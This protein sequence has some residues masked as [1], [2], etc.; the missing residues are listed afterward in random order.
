MFIVSFLLRSFAQFVNATTE[1]DLDKCGQHLANFVATVGIDIVIGI[2]FKKAAG[3]A[4]DAGSRGRENRLFDQDLVESSGRSSQNYT[5]DLSHVTGKGAK[6]RQRAI[7]SILKEDFN[8]LNF[9][10]LPEYSPFIRTGI[11]KKDAGT[12]IGK[13]MFSSRNQLRDTIVHEELHH[14]WWRRGLR[15]HHP[16]NS[17]K[18]KKFYEIIDR[19]IRIRGWK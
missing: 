14:R 18:E 3:K 1:E 10:H 2:L 12:Q 16:M 11:D 8:N 19:Y 4:K 17:K 13:N 15:D 9:T 7:D 5:S 6:A